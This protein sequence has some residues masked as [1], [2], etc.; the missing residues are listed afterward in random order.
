MFYKKKYNK[1]S[2]KLDVLIK[3]SKQNN[4]CHKKNLLKV[5]NFE[6]F[7]LKQVTILNKTIYIKN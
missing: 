3:T 5:E 4:I 6:L 7:D 2:K 1:I